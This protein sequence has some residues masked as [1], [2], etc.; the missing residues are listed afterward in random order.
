RGNCP[1]T[2]SGLNLLGPKARLTISAARVSPLGMGESIMAAV[3]RAFVLMLLLATTTAAL[4]AEQETALDRYI[5]QPDPAFA[6]KLASQHQGDGYTTYVIDL[7][8]Q[9]WRSEED[10]DRPVWKHWLTVVK[11]DKLKYHTAFLTIGGG[12]N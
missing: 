2:E 10:V 6:W 7:T 5:A 4:A 1:A 3:L 9:T 11:P 8:S 12:D